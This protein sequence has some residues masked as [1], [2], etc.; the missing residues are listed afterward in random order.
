MTIRQGYVYTT[1]H[2]VA[3]RECKQND[4]QGI[5]SLFGNVSGGRRSSGRGTTLCNH[6]KGIGSSQKI[7]SPKILSTGI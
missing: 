6:Q 3:K 5:S 4:P 2:M 7:F 1:S